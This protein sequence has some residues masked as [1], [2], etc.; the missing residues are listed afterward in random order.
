MF[1]STSGFTVAAGL[2]PVHTIATLRRE[3]ND[4]REVDS[5]YECGI[6]LEGYDDV[7][8]GDTIECYTV[9]EVKRV[10]S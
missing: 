10:L 4:A 9:T 8:V 2:L 1:F 6:K 3:K 5:G 7:H